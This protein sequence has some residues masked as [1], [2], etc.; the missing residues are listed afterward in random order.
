MLF[1]ENMSAGVG[2]AGECHYGSIVSPDFLPVG[3]LVGVD[4]REL[5]YRQLRHGVGR[6]NDHGE[7]VTG[8]LDFVGMYVVGFCLVNFTLFYR[9]GRLTDIS[10]AIN[11]CGYTSS[12]AGTTDRYAYI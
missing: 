11:E 10:G 7:A 8:D 3:Y 1:E 12:G 9:S 5:G 6:M 4:C 2:I